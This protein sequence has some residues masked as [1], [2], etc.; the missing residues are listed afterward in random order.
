MTETQQETATC[1][2]CGRENVPVNK[3]GSLRK[4]DCAPPSQPEP[5][6]AAAD[7]DESAPDAPAGDH[8]E[9]DGGVPARAPAERAYCKRANCGRKPHRHGW[10]AQ[11]HATHCDHG[12]S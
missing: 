12:R 11:D 5:E 10:C 6:L 2:D 3:S 9:G 7:V 1:P 4:H 8:A